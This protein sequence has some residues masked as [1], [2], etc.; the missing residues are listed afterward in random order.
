MSELKVPFCRP[1]VTQREIDE[2]CDTLRSGWLTT[3]PKTR[4]FEELFATY[5]GAKHAVAVNSCTAALH[6]AMVAAGVEQGDEVITTPYT[7]VSSSEVIVYRGAKPVFVDI[8][9]VT[10]NVDVSRIEAA[11][12][13]R[14]KA[15]LPVHIAGQPADLDAINQIAE[16]HGLAVVEDAAHAT[17][18]V[19]HGRKIGSIGTA[20][21]F[22]FY[23]TKN[24]ATGE[25]GM[26]TTNDDEIA[27]RARVLCLHGMSKD[28]WKRYDKGGS[29]F[30][31]I[32]ETGYKYNMTDIQA[33]LGLVQLDR[34]AEMREKRMQLVACYNEL[35][36]QAPEFFEL[37]AHDPRDTHAWHLFLLRLNL[38]ALSIDRARFIEELGNRGVQASVHFIPAHLHPWYRETYGYQGGEFPVAEAQYLREISLP[39]FSKMSLDQAEYVAKVCLEIAEKYRA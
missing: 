4:Q 34:I 1:D 9:P 26:L 18:S 39:L 16:K 14:T 23:A 11:I 19:Y 22:S 13:P 21:A 31:E 37:P 6:L 32:I 30:Y 20:T 35:L 28:A 7:F 15:I 8:D 17:E 36:G 2:V 38:D 29:W 24:L 12:T 27:A 3:G 10:L 5:A 33:A 25:G